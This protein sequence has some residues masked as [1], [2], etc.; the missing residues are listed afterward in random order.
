[1]KSKYLAEIKK[2]LEKY[3]IESEEILDILNDYDQL[4]DDGLS[5]GLSD[6]SVIAF[7]GTPEKIVKE[8]TEGIKHIEKPKKGSKLIALTPFISLVIYFILG[9][10][11]QVWHPG[12]LVFF[13]I[14]VT[15]IIVEM[16]HQKDKHITTALSPFFTVI[17]YLIIGF[18]YNIWHP[19]WLIFLIIP[20][21]AIVNSRNERTSLQIITALTPF[22]ATIT[23]FSFGFYL[24]LW[25]PIWL[26]FFIIPMVGVLNDSNKTKIIIYEFLFALSISIYLFLGYTYGL[27]GYALLAFLIPFVYGISKNDIQ[28]D[29]FHEGKEEWIVF[30]LCLVVYV[31][32][33][34][35][36]K[37]TWAYLWVIFFLVPVFAIVKHGPKKQLFV[38]IS[39][40][41]ATT[42]FFLLG[43]FFELWSISWIAFLIIPVAAILNNH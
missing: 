36:F 13:L 17:T 7:L 40:F 12:W 30:L 38:P 33:G 26:V 1:M 34:I 5:R 24:D 15:A 27:W 4:Y 2:S 32:L 31:T 19:T 6:E 18:T 22:I 37:T 8:L 41:L 35:I 20:V 29:I 23:F 11:F 16:G 28:I 21:L 3:E 39:P 14:P 25:N 42:I 9:F 43:Y 10:Y